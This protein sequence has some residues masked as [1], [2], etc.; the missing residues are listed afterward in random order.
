MRISDRILAADHPAAFIIAEAG[1]NY[2]GRIERAKQ[3]VD[4]IM[5]AGADAVTF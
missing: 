5:N 3:F 4:V 2:D 1:V